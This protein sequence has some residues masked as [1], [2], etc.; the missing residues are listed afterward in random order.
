MTLTSNPLTLD[1]QA[2]SYFGPEGGLDDPGDGDNQQLDLEEDKRQHIVLQLSEK[3][4]SQREH[5]QHLKPAPRNQ[6]HG[7][8]QQRQDGK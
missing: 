6:H 4:L 7:T 5:Q 2:R 1:T 3:T 8:T